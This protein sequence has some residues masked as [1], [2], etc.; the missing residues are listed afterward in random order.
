MKTGSSLPIQTAARC[1]RLLPALLLAGVTA[2][3]SAGYAAGRG[4]TPDYLRCEY[5]VNPEG[6]GETAPRLS[7]IVESGERAQRQTAYQ[8]LVASRAATLK[9]NHGDLWDTGKVAGD[10]TIGVAYAG[11]PLVSREECFW[12]VRVWDKDGRA[13]TWS[14]PAHWSMGLLNNG[15]WKAQWI[16]YDQPRLAELPEAP[17]A[18]AKWIWFA[19][20]P[21]GNAPPGYR[22]FVSTFTLPDDAKITNAVLIATADDGFKFVINTELVASQYPGNDSWKRPAKV[23]VTARLKPGAN[24]LRVEAFNATAGP[25]GLLAKLV[26]QTA[27]GRTFTHVTDASWKCAETSG[28][29][30]HNRTLNTA[31]WPA[32]KVIGDYGVQPWGK[33]GLADSFLPPVPF[34]RTEFRADKPVVRAMLYGTALGLVDLHLNGH[35]VSDDYFTPG[36]TDYNKRVYY[37]AYDVTKLVRAG[38]NALG[39]VLADGWFSGYVGYAHARDHYGKLPRV[40]AELVLDYADGTTAVV[41]TGPQWKAAVGPVLYADF[42]Q[43]ES[44]DARRELTGWDRPD[45]DDAKWSPVIVGSNEVHPLVQAHPGP[46]VR[47]FEEFRAQT[48]T[49][50]RPGVYVLNLGQNFAGVPRLTVNGQP[51]QK[52]TLRFAERLNPDGTIYTTNLRSARSTDTYVCRGG[53][54]EVWSPRFTFHGFQYVEITGLAH[55]PSKDTVVGLALSSATPVVGRF[56]CSDPMLNQIHRNGYYTQRA[57]F[58]DIPT[59]CPQRDERLGWTGDAQ[60]YVR[61]A[62]LNTDVQAFFT[63]WLVDLDTDGQRADGQFPMVAPVKVAGDDGGPAWADAGVIC[64]WTIFEVYGDRRV[65][66][67]HYEAMTRFIEFCRARSTPEMLP[68]KNYHC[69]GDWLSINADTP[70]DVIYMA[71]FAYSTELT[72]RAADVLGKTEDAAKYRVLFNQIKAAF[73]KTY[74]ADDG[75]IRGDTQADYVLALAFD[76]VDGERAKEAAKFL[77]ENIEK[78]DWHLSTGF[79]GTKD[80]M[81]ALSKIGREDVA[82]RLLH[83]DTFPSW[84]FSIKQ[85]ATSIWERWDGWTPEKGFQDPGMNSFAHYSFGAVYQWMVEN[86]GGIRTA[87]PA[88]EHVI[89]APQLDDKLTFADVSYR[90]IRGQIESHWQRQGSGLTLNVTIPANTVATVSLP[91]KDAASIAESGHPLAR[92]Q[93][94]RFLRMEDGRAL[95]AVGSGNYRFTVKDIR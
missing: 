35:R 22:L 17:L 24:D 3:C 66:E 95:L 60:V 23:D 44:C 9:Q 20:D 26:V 76:L 47:V 1:P 39:A 43:G 5:R 46:P 49:E 61:T 37:R 92:A 40:L 25:A 41:G 80:L 11:K 4:L 71:Y 30:W 31:D 94:V 84:G 42:L 81:L 64:P 65:L 83:N 19:N 33:L 86:I 79:I 88:Y 53:G 38:G 87:T 14:Q 78:R 90:S 57:N 8:V 45:Y 77:V 15:D 18:G 54:T 63:K 91:A 55:A 12:K 62:T 74:V 48:I 6:I 34:L 58:I 69:F 28:A 59:D 29:N 50:P 27:D 67:R 68:P 93:G 52:I 70:K 2:F 85:G 16:G 56:N 75:R 10:D 89:I 72:A 51:G 36:W 21:S 13:S 32:S 82:Y 7:W 73:N